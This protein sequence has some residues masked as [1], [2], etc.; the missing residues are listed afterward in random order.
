MVPT[1]ISLPSCPG[2]QIK[3]NQITLLS[4]HHSTSALVSEI[5]MRCSRQCKKQNKNKK[6]TIYI[7]TVHIYIIVHCCISVI[8]VLL[9]WNYFFFFDGPCYLAAGLRHLLLAWGAGEGWN[10]LIY[11]IAFIFVLTSPAGCT[12]TD[13]QTSTNARACTCSQS[14]T[15]MNC[16]FVAQ[17]CVA[18][19]VFRSSI[20]LVFSH[21][22]FVLLS[23]DETHAHC[24][25]VLLKLEG[26]RMVIWQT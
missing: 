13:D 20:N 18:M 23:Q 11:G 22:L 16:Q 21:S 5:L 25:C 1:L 24:V 10:P 14:H 3:S 19:V 6:T 7:W 12:H 4:H 9:L 15:H 2:H 26:Q 17:P 8:M